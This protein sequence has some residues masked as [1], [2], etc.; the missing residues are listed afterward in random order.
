MTGGIEAAVRVVPLK[1]REKAFVGDGNHAGTAEAGQSR[2]S[3]EV[4]TEPLR[5]S[6]V[7][8]GLNFSFRTGRV[9]TLY[10]HL[11]DHPNS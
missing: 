6:D 9:S 2:W 10:A 4:T 3:I 1:L 5:D 7:T 8:E 11:D